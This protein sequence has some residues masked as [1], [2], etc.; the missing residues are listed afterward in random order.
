MGFKI[1]NY[2]V[3]SNNTFAVELLVMNPA[4]LTKLEERDSD[5]YSPLRRAIQNEN[6]N[7]LNI[8]IQHN[9]G[10][11]H[12]DMKEL[13]QVKTKALV[14]DTIPDECSLL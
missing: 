7:I 4:I 1:L 5:G 14:R 13:L 3:E 9:V 8:L 11:S 2:A 12:A 10:I 6:K